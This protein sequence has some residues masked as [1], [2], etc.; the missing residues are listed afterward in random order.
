MSCDICLPVWPR[1]GWLSSYLLVGSEEVEQLS[2]DAQ[3]SLHQQLVH[4]LRDGR[5][6]VALLSRNVTINRHTES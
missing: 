2:R 3:V 1:P 4:R 6:T 5:V